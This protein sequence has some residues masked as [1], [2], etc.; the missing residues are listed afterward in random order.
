MALQEMFTQQLEAQIKEWEKQ[1][2]DFKAKVEKA[3]AQGRAEY[4]KNL[5]TLQKN[6]DQA[7]KILT[8]VQQ[9][10]EAAWKDMESSSTRAFEELKMGWEGAIARYK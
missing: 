4:E 5:K 1:T 6:V 2:Q 7:T 9:T 10:N 3:E 8:Q